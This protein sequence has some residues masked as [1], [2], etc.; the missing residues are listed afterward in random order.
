MTKQEFET[1]KRI[2]E[3]LNDLMVIDPKDSKKRL[4]WKSRL[5]EWS[6]GFAKQ[7]VSEYNKL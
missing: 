5:Y 7:I 4:D 3:T 2:F 6:E 1:A